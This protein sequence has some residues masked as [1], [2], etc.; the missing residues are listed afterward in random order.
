MTRSEDASS[1]SV[2]L[3]FPSTNCKRRV[4]TLGAVFADGMYTQSEI[5]QT[6]QDFVFLTN[7]EANRLTNKI[8]DL[9]KKFRS[10]KQGKGKR[11]VE[12]RMLSRREVVEMAMSEVFAGVP[13]GSH[14]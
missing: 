4:I 10:G 3:I 11:R 13:A 7:D 8:D 1:K 5:N 2:R 9:D 6:K 14:K 12:G